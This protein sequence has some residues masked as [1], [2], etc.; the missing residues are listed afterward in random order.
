MKMKEIGLA[1]PPPP[2]P[3]IRQWGHQNLVVVPLTH[4][5]A[6]EVLR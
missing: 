1:P 2:A 4:G 3:W 5:S 6:N